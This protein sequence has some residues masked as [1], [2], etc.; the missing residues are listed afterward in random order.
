MF[1]LVNRPHEDVTFEKML[2]GLVDFRREFEGDYWL[3]VFVLGAYTA[4][5][6]DFSELVQCVGLIG[7]DRVQLNTVTRPPAESF[8]LSISRQRLTELAKMLDPPAEVIAEFPDVGG[9]A[10]FAASRE[11]ILDLVRRRP[12][13]MDD[14]AKGLG[15]HRQEVVKHVEHLRAEGL[16]LQTTTEGQLHYR[17]KR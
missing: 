4:I 10:E 11:D 12:C 14:I 15:V 8:A 5:Q 17:A 6:A 1:R 13:S 16:L 3:E 7:P 2:A 9:L